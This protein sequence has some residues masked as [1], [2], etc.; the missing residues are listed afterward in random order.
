MTGTELTD[1]LI[2]DIKKAIRA[3][4]IA[5]SHEQLMIDMASYARNPSFEL[6]HS[7]EESWIS[8]TCNISLPS[9]LEVFTQFINYFEPIIE[10]RKDSKINMVLY[11]QLVEE[12]K[13]KIADGFQKIKDNKKLVFVS[14]LQ[15]DPLFNLLK[16]RLDYIHADAMSV[17]SCYYS[18]MNKRKK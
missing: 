5:R 11:L 1:R 15:V 7:I 4:S 6:N 12:N 13:Q 8:L 16:E 10:Y 18:L 2:D 3:K 9:D 17:D 14:G